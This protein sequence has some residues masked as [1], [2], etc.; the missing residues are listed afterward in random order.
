M[1]RRRKWAVVTPL[2][3]VGALVAGLAAYSGA[4]ANAPGADRPHD[5]RLNIRDTVFRG[6]DL[7][8]KEGPWGYSAASS[9]QGY[10]PAQP[11][12][13]THP[14]HVQKLG[15]NCLYCHNN[16]NKSPDVG[17]PAVSTC[18][19]CH[20]VIATGKPEIKRLAAYWNKKQP[21]PWVRIHKVPEYV[22]FPHMRHVNA[23]VTCQTCHGQVQ[24]MNQVYQYASLNMGWCIN[25]HVNGYDPAKGDSLAGYQ[26]TANG[27]Q[28]I[29]SADAGDAAAG[30]LS[31]VQTANAQTRG[32]SPGV[33]GTPGGAATSGR[34]KRARYDCSVCHY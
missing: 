29:K 8:A 30:A 9:D 16:A 34:I 21:V 10:S 26:K 27:Y 33:P 1:T 2:L 4:Q 7:S 24:K 22:H 19:G 25:C 28:P 23:G 15:M 17:M 12:A 18:M 20:T 11:V 3:A 32:A 6:V 13:F 14:L 31:L 5:E